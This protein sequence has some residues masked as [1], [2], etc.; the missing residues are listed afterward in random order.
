MRVYAALHDV[1][2]VSATVIYKDIDN[3]CW[4]VFTAVVDVDTAVKI[5]DSLN[6]D[7]AQ[8]REKN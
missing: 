4:Y 8:K 5:A 1:E 6:R 2:N 7:E 3:P